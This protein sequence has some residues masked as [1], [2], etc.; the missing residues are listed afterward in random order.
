[1]FHVTIF[2]AHKMGYRSWRFNNFQH[3]AEQYVAFSLSL[4]IFKPY[5]F[6]VDPHY[7]AI[8]PLATGETRPWPVDL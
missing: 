8:L 7:F 3:T 4:R 1:M 6:S 2:A 5:L